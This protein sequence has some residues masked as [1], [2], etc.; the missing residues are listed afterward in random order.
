MH[1]YILGK[2]NTF[3][4][5]GTLVTSALVNALRTSM[6]KQSAPIPILSNRAKYDFKLNCW[7]PY[8]AL[9]FLYDIDVIDDAVILNYTLIKET[10]PTIVENLGLGGAS[11]YSLGGSLIGDIWDGYDLRFIET[12]DT[13]EQNVR[14]KVLKEDINQ[15]DVLIS[16]SY[17]SELL[18][19]DAFT[20][21]R[22]TTDISFGEAYS[23]TVIAQQNKLS[24]DDLKEWSLT[25]PDSYRSYVDELGL[26]NLTKVYYIEKERILNVA[27]NVIYKK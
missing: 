17:N 16:K 1:Q 3:N 22:L 27:T 7:S 18:Q 20:S 19:V 14:L 15:L 8:D 5:N 13:R 11:K 6:L 9:G 12:L 24:G 23:L 2:L 4:K 21:K 26:E 25:L 10:D